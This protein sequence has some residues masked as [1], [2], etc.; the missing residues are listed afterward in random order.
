MSTLKT[1]LFIATA[2]LF[3]VAGTHA[4]AGALDSALLSSMQSPSDLTTDSDGTL[5]AATEAAGELLGFD[6]IDD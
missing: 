4:Q 3:A 1:T 6:G 5:A 2:A